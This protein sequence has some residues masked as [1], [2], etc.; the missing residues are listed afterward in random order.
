MLLKVT[1]EDIRKGDLSLPQLKKVA[2]VLARSHAASIIVRHWRGAEWPE[3][4][5]E[6]AEGFF[7]REI[8]YLISKLSRGHLGGWFGSRPG[9]TYRRADAP[10]LKG[11]KEGGKP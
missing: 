11:P 2:S 4:L 1:K 10:P 7:E 8:E 3:G 6:E 5:P 9:R